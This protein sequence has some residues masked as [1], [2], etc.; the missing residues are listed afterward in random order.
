MKMSCNCNC[1]HP[2]PDPPK[3]PCVP[4][5]SEPRRYAF[6]SQSGR[7]FNTALFGGIRLENPPVQTEGFYYDTGIVTIYE[8]GTYLATYIVNFPASAA[9]NTVLALQL[10]NENVVGTV[11]NVQK[12][13]ANGP[14][15]TVAQAILTIDEISS[16]RLSSSAV[17]DFADTADS[18]VASLSFIEI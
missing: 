16:V 17:I 12:T 5:P 8:P 14:Y 9:V 2:K 10:N 15:T 4:C 7:L 6:Y 1:P 18:T 11:R 13:A 3:P